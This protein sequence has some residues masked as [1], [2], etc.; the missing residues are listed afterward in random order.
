MSAFDRDVRI[1]IIIINNNENVIYG[2]NVKI[3]KNNFHAENVLLCLK[4]V[5]S[6]ENLCCRLNCQ[7]LSVESKVYTWNN[8]HYYPFNDL[9][10]G[11]K[12]AA[13]LS[14]MILQFQ[15]SFSKQSLVVL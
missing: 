4:C 1:I 8:S 10:E 13:P 9:G 12:I 15:L 2:V 5:T 7:E 14:G 3:N 6:I 11:E